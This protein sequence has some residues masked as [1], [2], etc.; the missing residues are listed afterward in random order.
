MNIALLST[1]VDGSGG[2][3]GGGQAPSGGMN[4]IVMILLYCVVIFGVM[5]FFSIKPQRKKNAE[6]QKMRD[7]IK[8]GDPVLLANGMF[9]TVVDITAECYIIEFGTNRGVR[10]PVIKQEVY[11]KKEPNLSNKADEEPV[12]EKKSLFGG[13]KKEESE[14]DNLSLEKK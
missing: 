3:A 4:P 11:A 6:M 2:S 7:A 10:I 12:P 1:V 14:A 8:T 9:G 5:Y 13:K